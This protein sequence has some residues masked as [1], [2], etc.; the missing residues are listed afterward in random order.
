VNVNPSMMYRARRKAKLKLYRKLENQYERLWD[1]CET[2]RRINS[3]SC[4]V[5]KVDKLNPNLL[6]KFGRMY[7]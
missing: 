6:P 7:V 1:Y 5:M 2:L 3:R 4:V